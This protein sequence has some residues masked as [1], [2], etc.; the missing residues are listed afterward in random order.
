MTPTTE[1]KTAQQSRLFGCP[2]NTIDSVIDSQ[3]EGL[4]F[5]FLPNPPPNYRIVYNG[6]PVQTSQR[7]FRISNGPQ[8]RD[9]MTEQCIV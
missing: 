5:K 3:L 1:K 4:W 2:G 8:K 7:A 6:A 9:H